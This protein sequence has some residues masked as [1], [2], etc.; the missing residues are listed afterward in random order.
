MFIKNKHPF[1]RFF[2]NNP[3]LYNQ[4]PDDDV[5][6]KRCLNSDW[7]AEKLPAIALSPK[8]KSLLNEKN[9]QNDLLEKKILHLQFMAIP[10]QLQPAIHD[11]SKLG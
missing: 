10:W 8:L 9:A 3:Q 4:K 6:L 11:H 5:F 1:L 7:T 2:V